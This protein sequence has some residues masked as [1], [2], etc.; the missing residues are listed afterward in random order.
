MLS[1]QEIRRSMGENEFD[2]EPFNEDSLQPASYDLRVGPSAFVSSAKET[3]DVS[4][5][6]LIVVEPGDF[7]IVETLERV[8][9]G[10]QTAAQLGLRSE[11]ARQGLLMM[12]GPQIDPGFRGSLVI[13]LVNLAPKN[14][15]LPYEAPFLTAQFFHLGKPVAKPYDGPRQDQAGISAR[16]I[17][18]LTQTEGL[19][20]GEMMKTLGALGRDVAELRGSVSKLAW[21]VPA[22]VL[23]GIA[24]IGII[25]GLK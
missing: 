12:S 19:T 24:V 6:G 5:K 23:F 15:A 4:R 18:E 2:I 8:R 14:V 22:I 11:Y 9:F 17:Q 7:A 1:D 21:S 20:L 13:R 10:P 16:D 25:V 3:V